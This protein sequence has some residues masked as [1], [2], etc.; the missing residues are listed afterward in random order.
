VVPRARRPAV[1]IP[2]AVAVLALAPAS[3][4]VADSVVTTGGSEV[5]VSSSDPSATD[6]RGRLRLVIE[7]FA[8]ANR[9]GVRIRQ[10]GL[11]DPSISSQD[12]DCTHNPLFNDV[13]CDGAPSRIVVN[14]SEGDDAVGI[15]GSNV[16]CEAGS[17]IDT[18]VN[19]KG[20]NDAMTFFHCG[21][22][23]APNRLSPRLTASGGVGNDILVGDAQ[24]DV[25]SGEQGNDRV[26][27]GLGAG[28]D[29]VRGGPGDDVLNGG[30]GV[31]SSPDTGPDTLDGGDGNDELRGE[32]GD[33][34]LSG[35]PGT[36]LVDGG[37]GRDAVALTAL[38][39]QTVRLDG[40]ANDGIAGEGDNYVSVEVL[41]GSPANDVIVGSNAAET[42]A[43]AAGNDQVTG[44]AGIDSLSGGDG[45]DLLDARDG[46]AK[47]TVSCGDG[48]DEAIVDLIDVIPLPRSGPIT[49]L[50]SGRC[51]RVERFAIDDG[52]PARAV[53][54]R[55][56][57]IARNGSLSV[58]VACPRKARVACRGRL[59]LADPRR[60]GRALATAAYDI[61][62]GGSAAIALRLSAREAARL[63]AAG[64]V[65]ALTRERGASKKGP[66]RSQQAL[67]VR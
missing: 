12:P 31:S 7:H 22:L 4:A 8:D 50:G 53:A 45:D 24:N 60:P 18:I 47:D 19:L 23:T 65:D 52:P 6:S 10:Q 32:G 48:Q 30:S 40:V 1:S 5:S 27:G 28:S 2:A 67:R 56:L 43:G 29:D 35:G 3:V 37:P 17:P 33:D 59:S 63:R 51:E 39:N 36:D 14:G 13:V 21:S 58:R 61:R 44:G 66:R 62:V 64:I 38:I 46:T 11:G 20:G 54:G 57:R 15:G 34:Q 55:R 9:N 42:L 41:T 49:L 26:Q 16:G 25:L